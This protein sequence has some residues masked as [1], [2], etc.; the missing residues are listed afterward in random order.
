MIDA[1]RTRHGD[2]VLRAPARSPRRALLPLAIGIGG[3][4]VA[5]GVQME[6]TWAVA[7]AFVLYFGMGVFRGILGLG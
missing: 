2:A 3:L 4:A 6:P 5:A 1:A 7:L